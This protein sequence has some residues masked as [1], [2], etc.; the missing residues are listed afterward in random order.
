MAARGINLRFG[1][2]YSGIEPTKGI[3][4]SAQGGSTSLQARVSCPHCWH[5][6]SPGKILW[7]SQHSDLVGDIRL[8]S[9]YQ[10][11][12]LPS[13]FTVDGDALDSKGAACH[14]LACPNCHLTI[15]RVLLELPPVFASI[16]GSPSS[17]KSYFL[18]AMTWQ[19]RQSL[20]KYFSISFGDAD[21]ASNRSLNEYEELLFLNSNQEDLVTIRKTE[22]QGDLYDSVLFG[23][24][25]VSFPRPFVFSMRPLPT[26]PGYRD[27]ARLS[28]A[29]CLY[30]NAGE[31]FLPG[32]DTRESPVTR[33]LARSRVL[34]F[35]FD[36]TQDPRFRKACQ[37]HTNDPQMADGSRTMRQETILLEAADRI[38]RYG[39]LAQGEQHSAPL[40]VV[41]TKYDAWKSL[42]GAARL[43]LERML[44]S[45]RTSPLWA[46]DLKTVHQLSQQ[47]RAILQR[48]SPEI[49]SAAEGFAR[50][51]VYLPVSALG[52]GPDGDSHVGLGI[53]PR[54]IQP[55]CAELPM[56]YAL[57]R[58]MQGLVPYVKPAAAISAQ[59]SSP[60]RPAPADVANFPRVW[61]ETGT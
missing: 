30:D 60:T 19:L 31:H 25:T 53:R 47:T 34:F 50:Q 4:V 14:S 11:R 29:L 9:D 41:V 1:M 36:P 61:G 51:V 32:Q 28:R 12:F 45:S 8:G 21:P 57:C 42:V 10:Q 6:F 37:G 16:L 43:D 18:A 58:W 54:D 24:Q 44:R 40:I 15:P 27:M 17:G 46:V 22:L 48:L 3:I 33:H 5:H 52:R 13:R 2:G 49:V 7:V 56:I 23:Q 20:S 39:G 59:T 38:R 35:L 26:H 55:M